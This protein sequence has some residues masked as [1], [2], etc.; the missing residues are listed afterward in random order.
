MKI[1]LVYKMSTYDYYRR[2]GRTL[3]S[4]SCRFNRKR[5]IET[6]QRHYHTLAA[7]EN[8]LKSKHAPYHKIWRGRRTNY[9]KFDLLIT[10]GG[11]GTF[12]E[13]ARYAEHQPVLG[14]NSDPR[15]SVGRY[16]AAEPKNFKNAITKILSGHFKINRLTRLILIKNSHQQRIRITND[17]LICHRIPASM[18]RYRI[19][20]G[21]ICEEQRGSGIWISSA[22]GSSSAIHSAGGRLIPWTSKKWQYLPRELYCGLCKQYRLKGGILRPG[23]SI[24]IESLMKDG[25][26]Y[27]DGAHYQITFGI[28]TKIT[29]KQSQQPLNQI[30]MKNQ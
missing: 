22:A 2:T 7:V 30:I 4:G 3:S 15:W 12:L 13:A 14:I 8:F 24:T 19:R 23:Q 26:I 9:A 11:D 6:H 29:I 18:S 21:R 5:F 16:C 20:V 27:A 28:G 1:L 17:A 10:V 25:M